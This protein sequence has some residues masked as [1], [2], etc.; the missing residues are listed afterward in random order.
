MSDTTVIEA[1]MDS[2]KEATNRLARELESSG[3]LADLF[4][5]IDSGSAAWFETVGL[6]G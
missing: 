2:R 5:R 6:G 1:E 3:A 4:A